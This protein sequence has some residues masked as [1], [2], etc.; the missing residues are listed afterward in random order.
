MFVL[1]TL[2]NTGGQPKYQVNVG[3]VF[4]LDKSAIAWG[5]R[6]VALVGTS[7]PND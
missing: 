5:V 2:D 7:S 6:L 4:V 1:L 3:G